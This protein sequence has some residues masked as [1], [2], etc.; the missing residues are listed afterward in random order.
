MKTVSSQIPKAEYLIRIIF[1]HFN[2]S[3]NKNHRDQLKMLAYSSYKIDPISLLP[4]NFDEC[5]YCTQAET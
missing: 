2:L 5:H 1:Q 3:S 4:V